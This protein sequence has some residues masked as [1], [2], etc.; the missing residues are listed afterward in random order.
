MMHALIRSLCCRLP[1]I[2]VLGGSGRSHPGGRK[3]FSIPHP[4]GGAA[5]RIIAP[6]HT[7][8]RGRCPRTPGMKID[9]RGSRMVPPPGVPSVGSTD[10]CTPQKKPTRMLSTHAWR[11]EP[12]GATIPPAPAHLHTTAAGTPCGAHLNPSSLRRSTP[13]VHRPLLSRKNQR[14]T[15]TPNKRRTR[16]KCP[17]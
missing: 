1:L 5:H 9:T 6:S 2:F 3:Q 16:L 15:R 14:I 7:I 13:P 11:S 12:P 10:P 4:P 8:G 17:G